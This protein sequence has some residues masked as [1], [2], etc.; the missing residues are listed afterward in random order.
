[1]IYNKQWYFYAEFPAET[2][3]ADNLDQQLLHCY[4]VGKPLEQFFNQFIQRA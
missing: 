4:E 2:I 3:L 1:M